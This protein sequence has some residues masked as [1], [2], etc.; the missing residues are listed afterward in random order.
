MGGTT[1]GILKIEI[2]KIS[3]HE[4][5]NPMPPGYSPGRATKSWRKC[6]EYVMGSEKEIENTTR[7]PGIIFKKG[8]Y[9]WANLRGGVGEYFLKWKV[10]DAFESYVKEGRKNW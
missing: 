9:F 4:S 7:G 2:L 1:F 5:T 3:K 8:V 10:G 6:T